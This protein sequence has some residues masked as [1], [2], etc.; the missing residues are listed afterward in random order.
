M[1]ALVA[2]YHEIGLKGRN[3]NFF[4][5]ALA[6]NI[7]RTLRG[8]HYERVRRGFG[9]VVIDYPDGA[10]IELA[11]ERMKRVLGLAYVGVGERIDPDLDAI[12]QAALSAVEGK[13]FESFSI[14]ARRSYSTVSI[15]SQDINISVGQAVKDATQKRV[16]LKNPDLT[17]WIELFG[18]AC[19]VYTDRYLGQGGLPVGV[20]GRML[21]L[22][23]GGIDSPVAA[24]R[25]MRRGATLELVHFHGQPFTDPSSMRQAADLAQVLTDFGLAFDLHFIPLADAQREIVTNAPSDLRVVLYRRMMLRIAKELGAE[26]GA[27]ALITGDSLGQVASQTI[28]NITAVDSAIPGV[29]ILR[30]LLGMDKQEIINDAR[31]IGTYEISTREHQDCCVLFEPRSP[32][33]KARVDIVERSERDLDIEAMVGKALAGRETRHFELPEP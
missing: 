13:D 12:T 10:S 4:E 25:M 31:A 18:S 8:T 28:E 26:L 9:R 27:K 16:D 7:K 33:T 29:Q 20:S 6:G 14:R 11:A 15:K 24:W 19:I 1:P 23:S 22:L 21:A 2:H 30:P 17:V 5:E 3:R 32:T